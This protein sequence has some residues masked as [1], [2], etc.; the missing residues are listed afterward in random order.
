MVGDSMDKDIVPASKA[1]CYT[2]WFQGEGWTDD[3]VDASQA[4]KV[5]TRLNEIL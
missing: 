4:D 3:P 1:G 2:I 5:I